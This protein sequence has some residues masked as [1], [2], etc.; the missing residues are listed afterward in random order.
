MTW[1]RIGVVGL[2]LG[3]A[4]IG[5]AG[6]AG[7]GDDPQT[8]CVVFDASKSTRFIVPRY[9]EHLEAEA[10]EVAESGGTIATVVVTGDP[11]VEAVPVS[12]DF[13][14]LTGDEKEG[15]RER[16][17]RQFTA[18]VESE[19]TSSAL[20]VDNPSGGSGIVAGVALLAEHTNCDSVLALSDGLETDA[21]AS[22]TAGVGDPANR[23]RILRRLE[24][25][26]LVPELD[27]K[28]LLFPFGGTLPQGTAIPPETLA[29]VRSFWDEYAEATGM[30]L[31]WRSEG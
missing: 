30:A 29:G 17:V 15:E 26:R 14:G 28:T 3:A 4:A 12:E 5:A 25:E 21:F 31:A 8:A 27:G 1:L 20:G 10:N 23:A 7:V 18:D 6:C 22:K 13:S 24:G 11:S 19:V 2:V 9:Q 16:K